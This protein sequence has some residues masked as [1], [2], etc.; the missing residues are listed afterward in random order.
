MYLTNV[1]GK[2]ILPDQTPPP[3]LQYHPDYYSSSKALLET[4]LEKIPMYRSWKA[5]DPGPQASVDDRYARMPALTKL[6]INTNFPGG[7]LPPEVDL[8]AALEK[9]EVQFI[10][11]SGT[12]GDKITNIW[13][14][15]WWDASEK[16]SWELNTH[17][18]RI[19]TGD[20]REAILVNP[21]NVGIVSD[22]VPLPMEDRRLARFLY[23][24][25]K[26]DPTVWPA[27][28]M[29][30]MIQE[31]GTF[32][33]ALLE[34]NPSYLARLCRYASAGDKTVFQPGAIV[35]TYEYPTRMAVAQIR[36]VFPEVPFASSYGTTETGY[37]F[38][39]C[40]A[41]RFHQNS[42]FCRVDFEPLKAMHRGPAL[43]RILV[44]PLHNP[45]SYLIHFETG[46]IVKLE[47]GGRCPCGR[48]SGLVLEAIAGRRANLTLACEGRLVTLLEL[49]ICL[50]NLPEVS[51]YQLVQLNQRSY[52]LHLVS[53]VADRE[54]HRHTAISLL[55][56]LYGR[57]AGIEVIYDA[58]IA[59][60][61]TGKYLVSKC[62]FPIDLDACLDRQ[63]VKGGCN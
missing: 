45:W 13:N 49:D 3:N 41:G 5:C 28:H 52:E 10:Q 50:S 31:I 35:F 23:L 30:R 8:P 7:V 20:H 36:Q 63:N 39:Q 43:G 53:H 61:S 22:E 38:L 27:E 25:E 29:G 12:T 37:V 32:Q 2:L 18:A 26:T 15:S 51:I 6:D 56:S 44:T 42:D 14:Q 40:E 54:K 62:L 4:A 19:A 55:K 1:E 34:A 21:R 11:T 57:E 58:D 46:D 60:E 33:P 16:S 59:P 9:G 47:T 17:L 48:E 24:N